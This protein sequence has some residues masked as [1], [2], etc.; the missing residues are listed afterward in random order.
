MQI[1]KDTC[2][3]HLDVVAY[4]S[5]GVVHGVRHH[6]HEDVP[7]GEQQAVEEDAADGGGKEIRQGRRVQRLS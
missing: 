4:E 7:R 5:D 6:W 3:A 2:H 1:S